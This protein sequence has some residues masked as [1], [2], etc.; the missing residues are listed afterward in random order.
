MTE[1]ARIT[2]FLL[3][4]HDPRTNRL[5]S[6]L[7]LTTIV[8]LKDLKKEIRTVARSCTEL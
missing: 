6:E 8:T 2:T 7:L 1:V 4:L 3:L 5:R